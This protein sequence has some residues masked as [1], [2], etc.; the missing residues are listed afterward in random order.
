MMAS[1]DTGIQVPK[2]HAHEVDNIK[3]AGV[4]I[5]LGVKVGK[6]ISVKTLLEENDAVYAA[7][8]AH[9]EQSLGI[10]GDNLPGVLSATEFL[11]D[12][13]LGNKA[14]IGGSV[15]VIG[16]GN[17]AID[18]A[19]TAL[20]LGAGKVHLVYRRM[21]ED[22][23]ADKA[24]VTAAIEEGIEFH[25]LTAPASIEAAGGKLTLKCDTMKLG[26]FDKSGR[27]RPEKTEGTSEIVVDNVLAAIGQNPDPTFK[28]GLP[29]LVTTKS[30]IVV[31]DPNTGETSVERLY[32]GGDCATGP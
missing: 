30:G 12:V 23:P 3:A 25:F 19:R 8:G 6:D 28:E 20:R 9:L 26:A 32:S 5:R 21:R 16:G 13:A 31:S 4:D 17:S 29:E 22:M 27:R 15:A 7:V 24:E 14:G 10:P 11:R 1:R 2:E 18:A